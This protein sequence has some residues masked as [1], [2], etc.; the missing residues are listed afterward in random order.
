MYG[1]SSL[2]EADA[3]TGRVLRKVDLDPELF[4]EG[5][6]LAGDRLFQLS[7]QS[8]IGWVWDLATFERL[9][10]FTYPGEGWGSP[11]TA[12]IQSDGSSQPPF[13]RSTSPPARTPR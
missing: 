1:R 12:L 11:T 13:H 9:R 5:L 4:A 10:Q 3:A 8:E 2:R 7:Y 6:A